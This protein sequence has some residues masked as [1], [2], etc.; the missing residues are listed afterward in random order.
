MWHANLG[1]GWIYVVITIAIIL[2]VWL[3]IHLTSRRRGEYGAP[4]ESPVEILN[5]RYANGEISKEEYEKMKS[6]I[7]R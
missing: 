2:I 4:G 3:I 6:D 5:R 1:M 7:S